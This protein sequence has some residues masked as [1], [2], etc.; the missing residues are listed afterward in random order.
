MDIEHTSDVCEHPETMGRLSDKDIE[1]WVDSV[2]STVKH[3]SEGS[4]KPKLPRI[5]DIEYAMGTFELHGEKF[6]APELRKFISKLNWIMAF[7]LFDAKGVF[8]HMKEGKKRKTVSIIL[9][10]YSPPRKECRNANL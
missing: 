8:P 4:P 5:H 2:A 6:M 10:R 1:T 9:I 3:S 7:A